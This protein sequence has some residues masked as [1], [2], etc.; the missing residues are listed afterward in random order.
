MQ[1]VGKS[2]RIGSDHSDVVEAE[3]L[4]ALRRKVVCGRADSHQ[5]SAKPKRLVCVVERLHEP[6]TEES[7]RSGH[8][9]SRSLP[10]RHAR[11]DQTRNVF[12]I[13]WRDRSICRP[14]ARHSVGSELCWRPAKI[15]LQIREARG[16]VQSNRTGCIQ[17]AL[18][19]NVGDL[20]LAVRLGDFD[21]EFDV[22]LRV[23][24]NVRN[25]RLKTLL[26][27]FEAEV[28]VLGELTPEAF[29]FDS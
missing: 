7:R 17:H 11:R 23:S 13:L 9:N 25:L 27:E 14:G 12:Q 21:A 18:R 6:A 5:L 19:G 16:A 29:L 2:S 24:E 22:S 26:V 10:H 8:E 20:R 4:R 1:V 3:Q 15:I 28:P